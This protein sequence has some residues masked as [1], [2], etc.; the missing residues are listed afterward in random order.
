MTITY[1]GHSTFRLKGKVGTVVTDPYHEYI[2]FPLTKLTADI[3]TVSHDHKDHAEVSRILPTPRRER[4]FIITEAGEYEVGGISV[5][6]VSTF[7][8]AVQGAERGINRVF[9]TLIDGIRVCHLGDLGH[10]LTTEQLEEIGS[11]DVLLCPVGGGFT[12]NAEQA[13][14]VIRTIEPSY[15]IPMHYNTPRHDQDLFA[16]VKPLQNFLN[17]FGFAPQPVDKLEIASRSQLPEETQ[18]VLLV[19]L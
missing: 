6:G 10:E 14:S 8:D 12:I 15:V 17:I 19:E 13:A 16:D 11:V 3:V 18:L 4:P 2:G 7:H 9:T 1:H 5:F